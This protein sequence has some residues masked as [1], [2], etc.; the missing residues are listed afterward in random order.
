MVKRLFVTI[1]DNQ[2][3]EDFLHLKS[4]GAIENETF[5]LI[6]ADV[7]KDRGSSTSVTHETDNLYVYNV[8]VPLSN[9]HVKTTHGQHSNDELYANAMNITMSNDS[10][11]HLVSSVDVIVIFDINTLWIDR[12]LINVVKY[13]NSHQ[14]IGHYDSRFLL[15]AIIKQNVVQG[16]LTSIRNV[17]NESWWGPE[18]LGALYDINAIDTVKNSQ[19]ITAT[20]KGEP[21]NVTCGY[22]GLAIIDAKLC[23]HA[24][25]TSFPTEEMDYFNRHKCD[26]ITIPTTQTFNG[27]SIGMFMFDNED[28][29]YYHTKSCNYPVVSYMIPWM[30]KCYYRAY[31]NEDNVKYSCTLLPELIQLMY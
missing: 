25:F 24:F 3:K 26:D 22:L 5:L 23:K 1:V 29:F 11:Q 20:V 13:M 16:D 15:G 12:L 8:N 14:D 30:M 9:L 21:L 7:T 4:R 2:T 10:V 19:I 28:I 27:G 18:T 6:N 31:T 17:E